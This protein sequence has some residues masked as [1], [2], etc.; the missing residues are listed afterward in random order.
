MAGRDGEL[1]DGG[2][3]EQLMTPSLHHVSSKRMQNKSERKWKQVVTLCLSRERQ[4]R[5]DL[6]Q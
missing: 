2:E 6:A 1:T 4:R 5:S 3:E